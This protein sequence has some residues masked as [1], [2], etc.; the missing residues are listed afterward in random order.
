MRSCGCREK[1]KRRNEKENIRRKSVVSDADTQGGWFC[2]WS[3]SMSESEE[4]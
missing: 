3:V 2:C 4:D 1:E